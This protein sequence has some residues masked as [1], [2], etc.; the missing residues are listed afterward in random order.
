VF[1]LRDVSADSFAARRAVS[2]A[3]R[4]PGRRGGRLCGAAAGILLVRGVHQLTRPR[5]RVEIHDTPPVDEPPWH[6]EPPTALDL[7]T[8]RLMVEGDPDSQFV[9]SAVDLTAGAGRY[10]VA[11]GHTGRDELLRASLRVSAANQ[12]ASSDDA[13]ANWDSLDGIERYL[14][15]LWPDRRAESD[16]LPGPGPVDPRGITVTGDRPPV[17]V[18]GLGRVET[19]A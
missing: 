4:I 11:L 9:V 18:K 6:W 15:R 16:V 2:D 8:G 1:L 17:P 5:V 14:I 19:A 12:S 13:L 3:A 7:A 10:G